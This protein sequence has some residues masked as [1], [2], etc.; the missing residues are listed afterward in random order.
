MDFLIPSSQAWTEMIEAF[1]CG[2]QARGSQS[3]ESQG[4]KE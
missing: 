2:S 1:V 4:F 3:E